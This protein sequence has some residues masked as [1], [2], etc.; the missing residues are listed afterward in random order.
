MWRHKLAKLSS[1]DCSC[2][3]CTAAFWRFYF[4][5]GKKEN[6]VQMR[7]SSKI[8]SDS[9][10]VLQQSLISTMGCFICRWLREFWSR[11]QPS[12]W[13]PSAGLDLPH[14]DPEIRRTLCW[15]CEMGCM[16]PRQAWACI[17]WRLCLMG[18]VP[19]VPPLRFFHFEKPYH[20]SIVGTTNPLLSLISQHVIMLGC[21]NMRQIC[22]V[23][24]G[25][26]T[27]MLMHP[28]LL[29]YGSMEVL[30]RRNLM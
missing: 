19:P 12:S 18:R 2:F 10:D 6:D 13:W 11:R 22:C 14:L 24:L 20:F 7:F 26:V 3:R 8:K 9:V 25:S 27:P 29:V 1:N 16:L 15:H 5:N 23:S 4:L 28:F 17:N 21:L 30:S